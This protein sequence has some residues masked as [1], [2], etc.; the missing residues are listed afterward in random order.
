MTKPNTLATIKPRLPYPADVEKY[1]IDE[2]KWRVLLEAI[3]PSATSP[4]SVVLALAYC[5]SRNL[6]PLKRP[7][8]IVPVWDSKQKRNVETI[9]PGIGELRTT[10]SRTGVYA[11]RDETK[12]GQ[13][14]TEEFGPDRDGKKATVTYPKW[15]QVTVY[16][17]VQGVRCAF[18]GPRVYWKETYAK[19]KNNS[20]V[21]NSMWEKRP[22]GQVDKCAEAASIRAAFPEE[23]GEQ[24]TA[25]EMAGQTRYD[26]VGNVDENT[27]VQMPRREADK[28]EGSKKGDKKEPAESTPELCGRHGEI[29]EEGGKCGVC[30]EEDAKSE[31]APSNGN[32]KKLSKKQLDEVIASVKAKGRTK[33]ELQLY[34]RNTWEIRELSDL[35]MDKVEEIAKWA[36]TPPKEE[37]VQQELD[38]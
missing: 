11:G 18:E 37:P 12:F 31:S 26:V 38:Q 15:A 8:H 6:D 36:S 22:R 29:I 21:P 17:I 32:G 13:D 4:A 19:R 35:T 9:W 16:K 27:E 3:F 20:D 10:A 24:L 2:D 23:V 14:V 1:G 25:E 28:P 5:K 33:A 30:K 7:I 34:V